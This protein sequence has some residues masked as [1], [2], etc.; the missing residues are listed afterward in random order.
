MTRAITDMTMAELG[1]AIGENVRS[2]IEITEAFFDAIKTQPLAQRIYVRTTSERAMKEA[3]AAALR[4]KEGRRFSCLDGVPISWKDLFDTKDIPTEMGTKLLAGRIPNRDAKLLQNAGQAGL[5]CLGKTHLSECAFSGLGLNPVAETTPCV[6]DLDA[7]SGGSSSGAAGSVAFGLAAGA[8]GSDTGGSVRIP[9][10]WNDLVGLKTTHGVLSNEGVVPLC[11]GFDTAGPMCKSAKD[12][13]LLFQV[14]AGEMPSLT[15]PSKPKR[16]G[17]LQ[18][19]AL[20]HLDPVVAQAFEAA[21]SKLSNSGI[22]LEDLHFDHMDEMFDLAPPTFNFEA[23]QE[24]QDKLNAQGHLMF[25]PIYARFMSGKDITRADYD[26][27]WAR[28][29][30]LRKIW[31]ELVADF[32]LVALPTAPILP[33]KMQPLLEEEAHYT[34]TNLMALRN[35]RIGNLL[36]LCVATL[37][38]G[39]PSVGV[40]FMAPANADRQLIAQITALEKILS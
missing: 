13:G 27:A 16:I 12:A 35:T 22:I 4:Q 23:Y 29:N 40:S 7:V 34:R 26:A 14:L 3:E 30:A 33:P 9:S 28:L 17:I 21:L 31:A 18:N 20:D 5:I 37:P 32:D 24:W 15:E 10:A 39:T 38:T 36:G 2:P 6:N 19:L 1:T 11:R 8:I 25:P